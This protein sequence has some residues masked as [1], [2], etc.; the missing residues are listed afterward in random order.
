VLKRAHRAVEV[1][2]ECIVL[3]LP[4]ER[5]N[6]KFVPS[7]GVGVCTVVESLKVLQCRNRRKGEES[8]VCYMAHP[9][10]F[11]WKGK[12][13]KYHQTMAIAF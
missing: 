6:G 3:F 13:R 4:E 1:V 12:Q 8:R 7:C 5:L 2:F 9:E 11:F 10:S